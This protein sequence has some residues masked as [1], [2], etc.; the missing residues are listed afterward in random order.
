MLT[1]T[2][3]GTPYVLLVQDLWPDTVTQSGM[4]PARWQGSTDRVLNVFV[5][6]TYRNAAAI[7]VISPGMKRLLVERGVDEAKIS[8]VHNWV[9]ARAPADN[10]AEPDLRLRLGIPP[11]AFVLMYAGNHGAAQGLRPVVDAFRRTNEDQHLVLVGGGIE[12]DQ[13]RA[14]SQDLRNVHFVEAQPS[15]V[16]RAWMHEADAQLVSLIRQP[17]FAVTVP[18]KLQVALAEGCPVLAVAEGDVADIVQLADAGVS[19]TPGDAASIEAALDAMFTA[20]P[21]ERAR[22]GANARSYYQST[23]APEVGAGRLMQVLRAAA[24]SHQAP[25]NEGRGAGQA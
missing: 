22:W 11:D 3:H 21:Q 9:G 25:V 6:A 14:A 16:V 2:L 8:V 1:R 23:M 19:A 10:A 24:H 18:S 17:L 5:N 20:S 12:K 15:S 4:L 13:L 7:V